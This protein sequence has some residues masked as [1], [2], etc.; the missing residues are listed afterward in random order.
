MKCA[1]ILGVDADDVS[2]ERARNEAP[3]AEF[4]QGDVTEIG[5]DLGVY[6]VVV[7]FDFFEHLPRGKE[8]ALL[9]TI[10]SLLNPE[11]GRLLISVPYRGFI[12]T[13]LD[14]AFYLGHRHYCLRDI[15]TKLKDAGFTVENVVYAGGIW[16]QLSMIWLYIL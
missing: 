8:S 3:T 7:M 4:T 12:S 14:P 6:D 9:V 15:E 10:R 5:D 16:E 2:L 13:A 1:R 11:G